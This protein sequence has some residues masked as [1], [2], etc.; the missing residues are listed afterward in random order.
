[1]RREWECGELSNTP[2]DGV[3]VK[4]L[5][6]IPDERGR[7]MEILRVDDL[8]FEKFG[9]VY[10]TTAYPDV[11]KAWHYHLHQIDHFACVKGMIK[12]ALYDTRPDSPTRK[13]LN[14]FYLGTHNPILVRI[15]KMV[16][17]GF[18]CVS[19]EEAIVINCPTEPYNY[20]NPDEF[21][22]PANAC[23]LDNITLP[24]EFSWRRK[25]G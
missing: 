23:S 25:D 1:M 15:P 17:H 13:K 20:E 10:M 24:A 9:Q 6:V 4:Q 11:T 22:K 16:Y 8:L 5:N 7:L 19:D 18:K 14:V 3:E 2:I 21:R 12:L